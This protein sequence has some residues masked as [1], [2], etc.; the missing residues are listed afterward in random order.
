M[1]ASRAR[2]SVVGATVA[3]AFLVAAIGVATVTVGP[4]I[5]SVATAE[6]SGV[7]TTLTLDA[8]GASASVPL[9]AG[10]SFSRA[11]FDDTRATLRSPDGVMTLQVHLWVEADPEAAAAAQTVP[12]VVFDSEPVGSVTV[13]HARTDARS[14][15]GAVVEEGA[16]L[17]FTSTA[18]ETYD[19]ELAA[20]LSRVEFSR[21]AVTP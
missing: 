3:G 1:G 21:I 18:P 14:T 15:V 13:L 7:D 5:W 19:A 8:E 2:A 6:V 16:V 10:W 11:L 20:F 4:T 9:D 17:A 12:N